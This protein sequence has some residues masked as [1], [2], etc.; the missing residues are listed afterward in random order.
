MKRRQE[1]TLPLLKSLCPATLA[2]LAFSGGVQ[3]EDLSSV[4]QEVLNEIVIKQGPNDAFTHAFEAGD[5][6]TE[7]TF[8]AAHGV[9]A[10][11]GEGRRFSRFPRADLDG[12]LE[13]T[14]HMPKREGG[15]NATSCIACHN[16]PIANGA[17]DIALNVLV[18]PAHTADPAKYLERNTLPLMALSVPQLL[19]EEMSRELYAQRSAMFM[20]TCKEGAGNTQLSAKGVTF[21]FIAATRVTEEPCKIDVDYSGLSGVDEDLVIRSFGWKGN[22]ATIRGFTRNAAHNELGLQAVELI[23]D[24]D[25]DFDGVTDELTVGDLTAL[26]VYMAGLERP[27]TKVEM[28]ALGLVELGSDEKAMIET[29]KAQ[30]SVA[31]CGTCHIPEMRLNVPVFSEPSTTPGF[32]DEVFPSGAN[33][34]DEHLVADAAIRI[35]MTGDQPNNRIKMANGEIRHLGALRKASDGSALTNWFTDFKRHDMG[36]HLA[37]PDDP[38]GIG[39]EMW[40]TRSLAGVGSTGPWLHDGRATTLDDA[41]RMHAGEAADSRDAY[42]ALPEADRAAIVAFLENLVIYKHEEAK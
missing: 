27:V 20:T 24:K 4:S 7:F 38:L 29:G 16:Q 22:Q 36:P 3:A 13:W 32:Y 33:P 8:T 1:L 19:A 26:T 11:V 28:A 12:R 42:L 15:P 40:L 18:D 21:G 31:Q 30:F 17:G 5:E 9:G 6:L 35:D 14:K 25:G 37:D 2:I 34:R 39:A 23:G 41:I 10:H